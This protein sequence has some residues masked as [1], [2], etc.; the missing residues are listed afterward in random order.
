MYYRNILETIQN[1]ANVLLTWS[2]YRITPIKLE[3]I[4]KASSAWS[5]RSLYKA[6][7]FGVSSLINGQSLCKGE[8]G[9]RRPI[10]LSM[11]V[12]ATASLVHF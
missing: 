10:F 8:F 2:T 5:T 9:N 12:L 4:S 6:S 3:T 1:C 11:E 7:D